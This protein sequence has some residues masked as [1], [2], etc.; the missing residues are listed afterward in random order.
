M[1]AL[2]GPGSSSLP[3]GLTSLVSL[4]SLAMREQCPLGNGDGSGGGEGAR[5]GRDGARCRRG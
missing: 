4:V 3:E 2:E 1:P 5:R